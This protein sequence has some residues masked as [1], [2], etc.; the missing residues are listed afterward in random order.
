MFMRLVNPI[1]LV[2]SPAVA[3]AEFSGK[4]MSINAAIGVGVVITLLITIGLYKLAKVAVIKIN[5]RS[6][7][8]FQRLFGLLTVLA[9]YSAWLGLAG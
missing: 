2:I 9:G 8:W 7:L 1:L 6:P 3:W 5:P 4:E